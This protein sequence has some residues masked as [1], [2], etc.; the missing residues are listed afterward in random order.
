MATATIGSSSTDG[1]V[2]LEDLEHNLLPSPAESQS[3]PLFGAPRRHSAPESGSIGSN[4]NTD[5]VPRRKTVHAASSSFVS[6]TSERSSLTLDTS[7]IGQMVADIDIA[8]RLSSPTALTREETEE[9]LD[10]KDKVL[11]LETTYYLQEQQLS[12]RRRRESGCEEDGFAL[13]FSGGGIRSAAVC[14]GFLW[15]F[16]ERRLMK[17]VDFIS[18]VSGGGYTG[19]SYISHLVRENGRAA[20][21]RPGETVDAFLMRRTK[22]ML[23][24]MQEP[25]PTPSRI[26]ITPRFYVQPFFL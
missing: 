12:L 23:M 15:H 16:A 17:D 6:A 7:F 8:A 10:R 22:A 20:R 18:T 19:C 2:S 11:E 21:P 9:A 3:Q 1:P 4:H 13:A 5:D 25:D 26:A 24:R 14:A